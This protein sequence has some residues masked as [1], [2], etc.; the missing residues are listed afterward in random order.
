MPGGFGN[1][2]KELTLGFQNLK[3]CISRGDNSG[4]D[5]EQVR[6]N[7]TLVMSASMELQI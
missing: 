6:A 4:Y 7:V 2:G 5:K 3:S 1:K